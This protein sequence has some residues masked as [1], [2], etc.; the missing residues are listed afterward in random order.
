MPE[1]KFPGVYRFRGM[2]ATKSLAPGR[3]VY[4][5]RLYSER[6]AEYRSWDPF[7]S[8]LSAAILKGLG[9]LPVAPGSRVLYLGAASG[10]TASHVSDIVGPKGAVYCVEFAPRSMRDLLNVAMARENMVP[11]MG[12]ARQPGQYAEYIKGKVD[13][14]YEDVADPSQAE[15]MLS[16]AR[17]F[18][19]AGGSALMAVKAQSIDVSRRPS[20]VYEE[21]IGRLSAAFEVRQRLGLEPF[22]R[23][24]LFL[25]LSFKG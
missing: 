22:D 3:R 2:L 18:L 13:I 9:V 23:H 6:G 7:R 24:H 21:A 4:G 15:I 14:I 1:E 8:K 5:E 11:I 17:M 25:H 19:K 16:N 10:T 20:E 12:D